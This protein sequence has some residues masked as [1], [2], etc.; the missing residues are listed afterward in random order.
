MQMPD[1][2]I[3]DTD[4]HITEPADVWTSRVARK[5][6]DRVPS[7]KWDAKAKEEAWFIGD[8]KIASA[9]GTAQAGWKDPFPSHPPTYAD[10]HPASYDAAA[11]LKYMDEIGVYAQVLYPNLGGFGSQAWW[12]LG[13]PELML[14][15]VR[16][17]NDFQIDW[18]DVDAKRFIPICATPYWDVNAAVKE[19]ERSAK[20]GHKGVLFSGAPQNL[21]QPFLGDHHWD[22]LWAAARD[23]DLPISFHI[24]SGSNIEDDFSRERIAC[25]GLPVTYARLSTKEF[26]NNGIQMADLLMSGVLPRFPE[27]KFVSVE[28]G[29]GWLPFLLESLDYHFHAASIRKD[30]PEFDLL[31]SD[32]FRRQVFTCYW[33]EEIAPKYLLEEIGIDNIMFETDFP[34]PTCLYGNVQETLEKGLQGQSDQVRKQILWDNAAEL[35]KVSLPV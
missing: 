20:L 13:E 12:K 29:I 5:W 11:R 32:Y 30:R 25:D 2:S 17:Y 4:T 22:P 18:I 9:A 7:V 16:A 6:R 19:I 27:L 3:I 35:Y 14:E 15:C 1:Y 23:A 34:H 28:S 10:A 24:G 33:F 8:K 21:G 31:P 26:L